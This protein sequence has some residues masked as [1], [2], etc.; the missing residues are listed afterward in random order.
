MEG[1]LKRPVR[2][3][4]GRMGWGGQGPLGKKGHRQSGD[5]LLLVAQGLGKWKGPG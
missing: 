5:W 3:P 1:A 2:G 4:G